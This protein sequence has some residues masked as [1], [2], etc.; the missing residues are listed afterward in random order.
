MSK[1]QIHFSK[2]QLEEIKKLTL[3][4]FKKHPTATFNNKQVLRKVEELL[5]DEQVNIIFQNEKNYFDNIINTFLKELYASGDLLEVQPFRYKLL[6]AEVLVEGKIQITAKG[7]GYVM[8]ENYE[9]DIVIDATDTLNALNGDTVKVSLYAHKEG[10]RVKGEV[11][12]VIKRARMEFAG[13]IQQS[14]SY[15]FL[16]ADDNRMHVDIF[17]PGKYLNSAHHGDKAVVKI[18]EWEHGARNPT[19]QVDRILGKPGEHFAEMNAIIIEYGLPE[20]FPDEVEKETLAIAFEIPKEEIKKRRD[21]RSITTFTIDPVDAKDFDDA[22]S[23]QKLKNGNWEI[24]VHIADV[25]HYVKPGTEL[26]KEAYNRA[27][28]IYL[29]DRVIPMLP[30]KLSN[31]VCSLR[32]GEDKL[33]YSAVF[34]MNEN[35]EVLNE[36][37]GK[38]IIH[39]GKRFTYEE[40]Q[41]IIEGK[42]GVLKS[43]VL[44]LHGLAQLLR[45]ERYKKGAISFEKSEVKFRLDEK[46]N[47]TGIYLK[48]NKDSNKLIE[49]FMLL[50][51]RKVAEF[52]SKGLKTSTELLSEGKSKKK[53]SAHHSPF[54]FVYRIHDSPVESKLADFKLFAAKFGYKVNTGSDKEIAHSLNNLLKE[55]NGKAEQNII[56]QLAIRSMAKAIY[57][58][59]NIGHYGLAFEYYSHFTS[60][61]RRYPDMMVH[62]LLDYYLS[63]GKSVNKEEYENKCKH[64]TEQEINAAEAER[65]SIKYKQVQYL[66]ERKDEIFKGVISGVTEWGIFVEIAENKCEGMIRLRDLNDDYYEFDQANFCITGHRTKRK[67]SLGDEVTVEIKN[68]DPVKKQIDFILFEEFPKQTASPFKGSD[69]KRT[70]KRKNEKN[71]RRGR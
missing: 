51:N 38:T 66:A 45:K 68:A 69:K 25:T 53:L 50:A 57:S 26:E 47:P 30:E 34:E 54:T 39:S 46:G 17:I 31:H 41:E 35:A 6:P 55:V 49:E 40:A 71:R 16:V 15:A 70:F 65:A 1:K 67:F 2:L 10:K 43:E 44:T 18:I 59:E 60:P 12:E 32:P 24:G 23:I 8:N 37:F 28:S 63:G 61:I 19:G 21:F 52:V 29:V 4:V 27:T 5:S 9:E 7:S 13:T 56:E 20:S 42:E 3:N 11:I 33:C 14:G 36:W 58:T 48:E 64:S 62:R 22:L